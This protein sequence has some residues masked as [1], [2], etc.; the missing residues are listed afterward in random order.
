[1]YKN[2][3]IFSIYNVY[4]VDFYRHWTGIW[5]NLERRRDKI[6]RIDKALLKIN[7]ID[8]GNKKSKK[9]TDQLNKSAVQI[10]QSK[11]ERSRGYYARRYVMQTLM[12]ADLYCNQ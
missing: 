7:C 11:K 5:N 2:T 10:D 12:Q 1:M 6:R 9:E 8:K 3:W 4:V